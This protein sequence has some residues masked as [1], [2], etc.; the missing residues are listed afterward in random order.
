MDSAI[1]PVPTVASVR[2]CSGDMGAEYTDSSAPRAPQ[3]RATSRKKRPVCRGVDVP[4]ADGA[5]RLR[6]LVRLVE[7]LRD[8]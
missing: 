8:A 6:H 4:E 5:H 3:R 7:H 1:T 2:P